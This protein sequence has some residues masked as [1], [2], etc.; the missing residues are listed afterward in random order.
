MF[1]YRLTSPGFDLF[2][3]CHYFRIYLGHIDKSKRSF[4]PFGIIHLTL[5]LST[6]ITLEEEKTTFII[7]VKKLLGGKIV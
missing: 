5:F 7:R 4:G 2:Q 6:S 1:L 3:N